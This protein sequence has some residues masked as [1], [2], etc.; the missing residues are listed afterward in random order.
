MN[1]REILLSSIFVSIAS[2]IIAEN[3]EKNIWHPGNKYNTHILYEISID[4][5]NLEPG[6]VNIGPLHIPH[7]KFAPIIEYTTSDIVNMGENFYAQ[8]QYNKASQV[9]SGLKG[10]KWKS[11]YSLL[12]PRRWIESYKKMCDENIKEL[13]ELVNKY[14]DMEKKNDKEIKKL[15]KQVEKLTK[16]HAKLTK[17]KEKLEEKKKDQENRNKDITGIDNELNEIKK[18]LKE[19]TKNLKACRKALRNALNERNLAAEDFPIFCDPEQ[20]RSPFS[21]AEDKIFLKWDGHSI[22]NYFRGRRNRALDVKIGSMELT[23]ASAISNGWVN[24]KES[25]PNIK[26]V[27]ISEFGVTASAIFDDPV[28]TN[29]LTIKENK[30]C[31]I[32][33]SLINGLLATEELKKLINF[34]G[35]LEAKCYSVRPS[36]CKKVGIDPF[37]GWKII[38][39]ESGNAEVG[40]DTGNGY[41]PF[42]ITISNEG[43]NRIEFWYDANNEVVRYA[44]VE[45]ENKNYEG[46]IP[47]PNLGK[48]LSKL[49]GTAKGSIK[50][51][52]TYKTYINQALTELVETIDDNEDEDND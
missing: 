4:N 31:T 23:T 6:V 32:N 39:T 42:K 1:M 44:K 13:N 3:N 8:R 16:E 12:D 38:V 37:I 26:N 20:N 45:I 48:I 46:N 41:N 49:N 10:V 34:K 47:N 29:W 18:R 25:N 15:G 22:D 40:Y 51:R 36:D 14:E 2:F 27:I 50:F 52:C 33:A 11:D 7:L 28:G 5:V 19:C 43:Q 24:L 9:V 30:E 35:V 17:N 21:M